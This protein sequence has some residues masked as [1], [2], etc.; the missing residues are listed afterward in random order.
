MRSLVLTL[1]LLLVLPACS[2]GEDGQS[3]EDRRAAYV[4]QAE[5]VCIA[6]NEQ[7][8]ELGTPTSIAEI[9]AAADQAVEIV[10]STVDEITALEPPEEDRAEVTEKVLEPLA[11]DVGRA[12]TYAEEVRAA[13]DG[14]DSATL[15]GLVSQVPSTTADVAFMR[16][17]GLVECAKAAELA[18]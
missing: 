11:D 5:E 10:R 14:G 13:A 18:G 9:P 3:L 8:Q 15:L 12:E 17:Y 7:V 2:G 6:S 16:D 1:P 4:E